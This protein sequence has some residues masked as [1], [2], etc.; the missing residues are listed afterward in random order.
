MNFQGNSSFR[1]MLQVAWD[2][3]SIG[4]LKEC[5][6]KYQ[7]MM[8]L[9]RQPREESIHLTF[10]LHYHKALEIYDHARSSGLDHSDAQLRAVQYC[11]EAT[12]V[13]V[14]RGGLGLATILIRTGL[15]CYGVWSGTLN[16]LRKMRS[17]LF[18]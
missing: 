16:S 12:V 11:Y 4:Y 9:G 3:T 17:R 14:R 18:N 8:V 7:Y 13:L 6:R 5:P 2:S 10:G 1:D 15:L